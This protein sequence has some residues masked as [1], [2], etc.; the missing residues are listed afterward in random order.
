VCGR[1]LADAVP[2]KLGRCEDC[3]SSLDEALFDRLKTWRL[4]RS[5]EA[6]LPAFCV[7]TDA[8]LLAIA[9]TVPTELAALAAIPGVGKAKLDKYGP[10]VLAICAGD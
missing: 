2:R 10:D 9:E 7:F 5:R 3:P 6:S 4:E 1:P 8:T